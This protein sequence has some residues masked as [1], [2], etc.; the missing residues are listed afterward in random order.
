LELL[1]PKEKNFSISYLIRDGELLIEGFELEEKGKYDII[2]ESTEK[3][4][5]IEIFMESG[6]LLINTH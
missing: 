1:L 2:S 4:T 5:E 6:S 3:E